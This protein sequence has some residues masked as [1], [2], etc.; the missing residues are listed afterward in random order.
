M[1]DSLKATIQ[2]D[3]H[4][5]MRAKQEVRVSTLRMALSAIGNAEVAGKEA[6]V[7]SDRETITV[8][9]KEAKKRKESAA[10]YR[11]AGRAETA[12]REEAEMAVLEGYL[13][14]QLGEEEVDAVVERAI[15]QVGATSM[16]QMGQVMALA[17]QEIAGRADGALVAGK[18]KARLTF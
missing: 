4:E 11:E 6:R 17:Q 12:A 2:R 5:A 7:L 1:T 14:K 16:A 13:P 9:T 15:E 10:V 3:L 18:V 8:L